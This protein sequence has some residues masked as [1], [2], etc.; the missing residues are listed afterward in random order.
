M[1]KKTQQKMGLLFCYA[2]IFVAIIA[3]VYPTVWIVGSALNPANSLY[4]SRI[5]PENASLKN[6]KELLTSE[7]YKFKYWYWNSIKIGALNSFFSVILTALTAYIFS[8]TR[9]WGRKYGLMTFLIIQMFP[10]MMSMVAIYVLLNMF[11]LLDTHTGILIVYLG[12]AV[13]FS[14]W[15]IKGYFDTIPSSLV[16]AA[17]IDGASRF[18]IFWQIMLP[19]AKP[20]LAVVAMLNFINPFNDFLL[21][22]L[23]LRSPEKQTLAVGL[24]QMIS[25]QFSNDWTLFSAGAVLAAVPIMIFV[26]SMQKYF[27]GGLAAGSTK[28]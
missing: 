21:A 3:V 23:I 9:F 10:G 16:E 5:I 8:K 14:T 1:S 28:G 26:L 18:R 7:Q 25:A 22:Q 2:V 13:P 17:T 24:Y 11:G 19:L 4:S 6:F 20:M 12:G 15:M 27:V